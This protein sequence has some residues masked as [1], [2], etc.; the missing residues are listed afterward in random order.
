MATE[1]WVW[2][3]LP[4]T[5]LHN[6]HISQED[7]THGF[8]Q[9]KGL[10]TTSSS[11]K[12]LWVSMATT[13]DSYPSA[14]ELWGSGWNVLTPIEVLVGAEMHKVIC[15]WAGSIPLLTSP[16]HSFLT[17]TITLHAVINELLSPLPK[18]AESFPLKYRLNVILI[19]GSNLRSQ[20]IN[21]I[22]RLRSTILLNIKQWNLYKDFVNVANL[23]GFCIHQL[24]CTFLV[25]NKTTYRYSLLLPSLQFLAGIGTVLL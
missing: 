23:L 19:L 14:G 25:C 18:Q 2:W 8:K 6:S 22:L 12:Y 5:R 13:G 16:Y 21:A 17:P 24:A 1:G 7:T 3:R 9:H 4:P 15:R 10:P 11:F 20:F